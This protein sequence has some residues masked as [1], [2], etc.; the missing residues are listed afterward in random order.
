M[1]RARQTNVWQTSGCSLPVALL[2][3][4]FCTAQAGAAVPF[5]VSQLTSNSLVDQKPQV[6]GSN[7]VWQGE[8]GTDGGSDYEIFRYDGTSTT[9]LTSNALPDQNPHVSSGGVVWERSSGA[10][11]EVIFL[12]LAGGAVET[13]LS[14][15]AV[16][17]G[18]P[19]ISG[20]LVAW[21]QGSGNA[22]EIMSWNGS[23]TVS[24]LSQNAVVDRSPNADNGG[25]VV[26]VTGSTPD[27]QVLFYNGTSVVPIA[28]STLAMNTPTISGSHVA[29]QGYTGTAAD[30]SQSEIFLYDGAATTQLTNDSVA[31]FAPQVS[32]DNVVWWGGSFNNYQVF[33]YDGT[34]HQLSG[35]T[36]NQYPRIDGNNVVWQGSDG[37]HMQIYLWNGH[38]V[39]QL[40]N[41]PYDSTNPQISGNHVVWQGNP[42]TS[43]EIFQAIF[44]P[45]PDG[46]VLAALALAGLFALAARRR[47]RARHAAV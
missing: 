5:T 4:A 38:E 40:T 9:C 2:S 39:T 24:N 10:S 33:L 12:S 44:V 46:V 23:T 27:Q 25:S 22:V 16:Q 29:W 6:W 17:D 42:G 32:G 7:V 3:L 19:T 31:D 37:Q 36:L 43:L 30:G 18:N 41:T 45:E 28:S 20:N 11:E 34:V 47:R 14:N 26:W 15:N 21:E 8:G 13:P 1:R 35:G